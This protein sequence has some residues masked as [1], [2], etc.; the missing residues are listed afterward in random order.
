MTI[1]SVL[2]AIGRSLSILIPFLAIVATVMLIYGIVKYIASG[3]DED[4]VGD[5]R[6]MIL[7]G[8]VGLA[9]MMGIWAIV[10]ILLDFFG[11]GGAA[12]PIPGPDIVPTF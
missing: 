10:R 11:L 5:A 7:Y 2:T 6:R 4:K 1:E 12:V 9:L 3:G 8:V